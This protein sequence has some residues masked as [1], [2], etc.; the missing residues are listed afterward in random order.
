MIPSQVLGVLDPGQLPMGVLPTSVWTQ[1]V[2]EMVRCCMVLSPAVC[3]CMV[4]Y[5]AAVRCMLLRT[6][7]VCAVVCC[8]VLM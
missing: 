4:L 7:V 3:C 5:G 2:T 1:F 6:T 8:C